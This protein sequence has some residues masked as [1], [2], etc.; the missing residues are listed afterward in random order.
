MNKLKRYSYTLLI[1]STLS[2]LYALILNP[3]DW[4]V[5]TISIVFIPLFIISL[6]LITM[7][8]GKKDSKEDRREEPFIGY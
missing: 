5:Y 1:I 8:N 4:I 3:A 6:G 2:I 7:A